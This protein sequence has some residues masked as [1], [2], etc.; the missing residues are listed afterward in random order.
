[1]AGLEAV[2]VIRD[3]WRLSGE[4]SIEHGAWVSAELFEFQTPRRGARAIFTLIVDLVPSFHSDVGRLVGGTSL[5]DP[6]LSRKNVGPGGT[7][8]H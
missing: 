6:L 4:W 7:T 8:A 5:L 2:V 3:G 1:M